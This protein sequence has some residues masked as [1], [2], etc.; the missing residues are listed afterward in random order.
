[1]TKTGK[2]FLIIAVTIVLCAPLVIFRRFRSRHHRGKEFDDV[3]GSLSYTLFA[4]GVIFFAASMA[5]V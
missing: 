4:E 3:Y 1:M 5:T 2:I